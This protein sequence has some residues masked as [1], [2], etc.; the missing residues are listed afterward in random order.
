MIIYLSLE[1]VL[2]IHRQVIAES[3]GSAGIR[4]VNLL[5]SAIHRP[6]ASFTGFDL[7]PSLAEKA[8]A[9]LHSL[10]MNHPFVDGNKRAAFTAADVFLRLNGW[11][12]TASEDEL[13]DFVMA[14][15]DSQ[16]SF[17]QITPWVEAHLVETSEAKLP[18]ADL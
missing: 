15:A 4:D 12:F 18:P 8:A 1:D 3:G 13:F 7:Y 16:L 11:K 5:D 9:L 10:V 6:Q 14:V 17:E 2:E